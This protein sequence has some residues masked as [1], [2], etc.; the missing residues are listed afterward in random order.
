MIMTFVLTGC[1]SMNVLNTSPMQLVAWYVPHG[2]I[3][4][5][6]AI[7]GGMVLHTLSPRIL[8]F[9]TGVAI[10]IESLLF[11]LAPVDASYWRWIFIPMVCLPKLNNGYSTNDD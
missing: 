4:I 9:V 3:E 7:F 1:S 11:A 2:T 10:M 8:M 6:L 5:L